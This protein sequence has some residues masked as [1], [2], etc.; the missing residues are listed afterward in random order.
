MTQSACELNMINLVIAAL[1]D[2]VIVTEIG[3]F[4]LIF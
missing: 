3:A 2:A 1:G 4:I